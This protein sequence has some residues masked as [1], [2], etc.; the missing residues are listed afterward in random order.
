M[1]LTRDQILA[2]DDL[3]REEVRVPEWGGSV[4]VRVLTGTEREQFESGAEGARGANHFRAQLVALATCDE[5][6]RSLF[7]AEDVEQL[8]SKSAPALIR[9]FDVAV[10][11]SK[12]SATDLD[13]L[14]KKSEANP[15]DSS[16][17]TSQAI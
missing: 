13:E 4:Y 3:K 15:S 17:S 16:S 2:T 1:L 6:G 14:E 10:R 9:V 8:A 11:L 7:T 5:S 12:V